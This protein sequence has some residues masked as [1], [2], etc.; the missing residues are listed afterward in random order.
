MLDIGNLGGNCAAR[1]G[2]NIHGQVVGNSDLADV[3]AFPHAFLWSR[4]SG[5]KDLGTLGGT[6]AQADAVNDSGEVVGTSCT[7]G[8]QAPRWLMEAGSENSN[9]VPEGKRN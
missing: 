4:E 9:S 8:D 1:A 6:F 2:L 3:T 5:I 7:A